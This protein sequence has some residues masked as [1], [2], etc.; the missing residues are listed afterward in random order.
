MGSATVHQAMWA[1]DVMSTSVT[2]MSVTTME[3]VLTRKGKMGFDV[4]LYYINV[5]Q[6]NL[7]KWKEALY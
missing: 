6:S 1:S 3:L 5:V 7:D 4:I 2:S